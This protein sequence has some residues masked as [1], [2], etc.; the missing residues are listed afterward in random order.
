MS[1][2]KNHFST[3]FAFFPLYS[4]IGLAAHHTLLPVTPP[5]ESPAHT[6]TPLCLRKDRLHDP[7]RPSLSLPASH[8][9]ALLGPK[10][11][12]RISHLGSL[13]R[14][15]PLG[16]VYSLGTRRWGTFAVPYRQDPS[17][18]FVPSPIG[19]PSGLCVPTD[20]GTG[21]HLRAHEPSSLSSRPGAWVDKETLESFSHCVCMRVCVHGCAPCSPSPLPLTNSLLLAPKQQLSVCGETV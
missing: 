6:S 5:L 17:P 8:P 3:C 19:P 10:A 4:G 2:V 9:P 12:R 15:H 11:V 1:R 21:W 7:I 13:T 18:L 20:L 16:R 14:R